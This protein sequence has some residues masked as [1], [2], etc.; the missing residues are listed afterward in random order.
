MLPGPTR[1]PPAARRRRTHCEQQA[2][3]AHLVRAGRASVARK[4]MGRVGGA[5]GPLRQPGGAAR[6]RR[7]TPPVSSPLSAGR[8]RAPACPAPGH[9][10]AGLYR[11]TTHLYHRPPTPLPPTNTANRYSTT[12]QPHPPTNNHNQR[13]RPALMHVCRM[14]CRGMLS[15]K[16]GAGLRSFT[17]KIANHV[18]RVSWPEPA[19]CWC[20]QLTTSP[21]AARS[22]KNAI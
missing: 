4:T 1:P 19:S 8:A 20:A 7:S 18:G 17:A 6:G 9:P 21:H 12:T 3:G 5:P 10:C 11:A 16:L 2:A 15:G 14:S 22:L 13:N